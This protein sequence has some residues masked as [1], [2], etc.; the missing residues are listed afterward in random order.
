MPMG[1]RNA[2]PVKG[3][4]FWREADEVMFEFVI[5]PG[6]IIGPRA[7]FKA[8]SEKYP[9]EWAAFTRGEEPDVAPGAFEPEPA[10]EPMTRVEPLAMDG[11][12][13]RLEPAPEPKPKRAYKRKAA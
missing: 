1:E 13:A 6:N 4:R 7:A 2:M 8:D 11:F 10:A 12:E 9:D 3:A 5:D